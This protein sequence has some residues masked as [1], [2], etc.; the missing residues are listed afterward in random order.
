[1]R[2]VKWTALGA[3]MVGIALAWSAAVWAQERQ[4]EGDQPRTDPQ[5]KSYA[6]F[7]SKIKVHATNDEGK[8]WDP[9]DGK[10]D[11]VVRIRN[12]SDETV[13]TFESPQK[14]DTLEALFDLEASRAMEGHELWFEVVDKDIDRDDLIGRATVKVTAEM[15][16][17]Q[18][19]DLKFGHV[20]ALSIEF[21]ER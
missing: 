4:R 16:R 14:S 11:I 18:K 13:K 7:L 9:N 17:Q 15:L 10:P 2:A 21:R 19:V 1:M 5:K 6:V 12:L 8:S 20:E 3:L